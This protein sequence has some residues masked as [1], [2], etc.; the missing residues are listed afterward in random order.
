MALLEAQNNPFTSVLFVGAADPEALP[1][2]DPSA[3]LYRLVID[4]TGAAWIVDSTGTATAV[5]TAAGAVATDAIWDAAGD[6][7]QGTGANT[8]AKL[9]AGTAGKVLTS[10]GAAAALTWETPSGAGVSQGTSFP[11]S[12]ATNLHFCRT[13]LNN[14]EF[15]YDGTRWRSVHIYEMI[16]HSPLTP[17]TASPQ[18]IGAGSLRGHTQGIYWL[19]HRVATTG[20]TNDGSNY[21]TWNLR[22]QQDAGGADASVGTLSAISL[23]SGWLGIAGTIN[24]VSAA[25]VMAYV[26]MAKTGSPSGA[27]YVYAARYQLIQT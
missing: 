7:V 24:A 10:N 22:D 25:P 15:F 23:G 11:G 19:D 6:L 17:N 2:A 20:G 12:P 13:D 1:D 21:W 4:D 3:G 5:T 27:Y 8:A 16:L 9:S 18:V 26:S 14:A